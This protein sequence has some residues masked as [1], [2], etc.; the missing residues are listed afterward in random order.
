MFFLAAVL[1][2]PTL[3]APGATPTLS[4]CPEIPG[5]LTLAAQVLHLLLAPA[6]RYLDGDI[7]FSVR[8]TYEHYF[9]IQINS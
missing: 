5:H 9:V 4:T 1:F 8:K 2:A 3:N 6:P 7:T